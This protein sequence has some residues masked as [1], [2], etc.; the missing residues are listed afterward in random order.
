MDST[1]DYSDALLPETSPLNTA[2]DE[3]TLPASSKD[4]EMDESEEEITSYQPKTKQ[5]DRSAKQG[6]R[7]N[8]KRKAESANLYSLGSKIKKTEDSIGKL[9]KHLSY[10]A[11]ADIP[12]DEQFKKDI[13]AALT[14]FNY[15]HLE[16]QKTRLRKEKGK[17]VKRAF[18]REALAIYKTNRC[19][20]I[21]M[22]KT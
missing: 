1:D 20:R 21:S 6:Q 2:L 10:N 16:K 14:R 18:L 19:R 12:L 11:R 13:Q 9:Q 22:L 5:P 3:I 17:T 8:R 4:T 15:R 7:N